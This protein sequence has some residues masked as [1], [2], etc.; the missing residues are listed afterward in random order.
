MAW[1]IEEQV[2]R[3]EIDN[4]T[5]GRVIGKIWLAGRD[6]AVELDL[7][8]NPWRDLAGHL[9]KFSNPDAQPFE[10]SQ[11]SA[12]QTGAVGD[13]TASRKVKVPD[14]SMEEMLEFYTAKQPFPWHWGNSL[15]LEWF[16]Q[17]NG[18]IVI[19][20]ATY[21]LE[22]D[23]DPA[24][25]MNEEEEKAQ[26]ASNAEAITRFMERIGMA[27]SVGAV[28]EDDEDDDLPQSSEEARAEAEDE[29]MQI[30][31]DRV[32]A[33]LDRGEGDEIEAFDRIYKEERARL[34]RERGEKDPVLTPEQI[35]ERRRWIEEMNAIAAE[36]MA[37]YEAEKWKGTE[38]DKDVPQPLV[39]ECRNLAVELH[40]QIHE[41]GWLPEDAH[42]EHP[43]WEIQHGV[44]S[45]NAKLAGAL[46]MSLGEEEWPPD[47]II[48]GNVI[49]R[50]K[51]ARGYLRDAL[52]GIDSAEEESLATPQWRHETRFK[53]IDVLVQAEDLLREARE[54]L[55]EGDDD[56]L[57]LS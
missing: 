47:R 14:C 28:D 13:M 41:A 33:R 39:E 40:H 55:A 11:I 49:V 54:V 36:A 5:P 2:L 6:E 21:Q 17:T 1:R 31:M 16:S 35:E 43:L 34:K 7:E 46:G 56:E 19:E 42:Q 37:D 25:I 44:S 8:G 3:G 38:Q 29:R 50:L 12:Y 26:Q 20:S 51:K 53:I 18:R 4:R 52:R 30:L 45:A 15:Y 32:T 27:V 57:G 23:A 48:A 22:L 9:L 24:W 10:G